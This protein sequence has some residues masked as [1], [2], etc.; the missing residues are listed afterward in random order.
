M[1]SDTTVILPS[2]PW[3][4]SKTIEVNAGI[5]LVSLIGYMADNAGVLHISKD[6]LPW[7]AFAI[8]GINGLLRFAT[9]Q[10][11]SSSGEP[12][13]LTQ[14]PGSRTLSKTDGAGPHTL[15]TL[16]ASAALLTYLAGTS[17][18]SAQ[19]PAHDPSQ[20]HPASAGFGHEHGDA[21]PAWL[22]DFLANSPDVWPY[23]GNGVLYDGMFN[24][25]PAENTTK[26]AAFKGFRITSPAFTDQDGGWVDGYAVLHLSSN[27]MD[28]AA[29][30]HSGRI[31]IADKS[32]GLS[33]RQGW[34]DTGSV[35][36]SRVPKRCALS[37]GGPDC[38]SFDTAQRPIVF[39]IDHDTEVG[40]YR[41]G[42]RDTNEQWYPFGFGYFFGWSI[43]DATTHFQ[44]GEKATDT[45]PAQWSIIQHDGHNNPGVLRQVDITGRKPGFSGAFFTNQFGDFIA[46]PDGPECQAPAVCLLQYYSPTYA[47]IKGRREVSNPAAVPT[48]PGN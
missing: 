46:N 31:Y 9:V 29:R 37:T 7:F 5:F 40:T 38:A 24:T 10:P 6:L 20:W 23:L 28:R 43:L 26:H 16:V 13:A 21:P 30:F 27:P 15:L 34:L 44:P 3:Y 12:V 45:D 47:G 11:V 1:A 4:L 36:S 8:F 25:S 35:D 32:G 14:K 19:A 18:A 33:I 17:S 41:N 2:K 42:Q 39:F 22:S 48:N